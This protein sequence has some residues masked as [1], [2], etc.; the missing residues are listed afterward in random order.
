VE[1][2]DAHTHN[3]KIEK[4][5]DQRIVRKTRRKI[6]FEY[7]VKWKDHP[8]KDVSWVT[9]DDIQKHGKT[10]QELMDRSW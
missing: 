1:T 4:I 7:L 2:T 3:S 5:L 6:Y 8:T 9:E 10:V